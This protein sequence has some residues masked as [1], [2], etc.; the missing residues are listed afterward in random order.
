MPFS[1]VREVLIDIQLDAL[2]ERIVVGIHLLQIADQLEPSV[3][4]AGIIEARGAP[5]LDL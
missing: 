3:L 5:L 2:A 1:S 4:P